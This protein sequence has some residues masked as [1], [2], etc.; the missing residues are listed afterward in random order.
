MLGVSLHT[1]SEGICSDLCQSGSQIPNI[2]D[3]VKDI[4]VV[5]CREPK[6]PVACIRR[7]GQIGDVKVCLTKRAEARIQR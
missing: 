4:F 5:F 6:V 1:I 7:L 3:Y 2:F